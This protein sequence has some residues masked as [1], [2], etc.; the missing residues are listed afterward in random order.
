MPAPALTSPPTLA[1]DF[2]RLDPGRDERDR[3]AGDPDTSKGSDRKSSLPYEGLRVL[4]LGTFWAAPF[5]GAYLGSLG[6]EVIKIESVQRPDPFRYTGTFQQLGP[7]WQEHGGLFQGTNLNKRNITLDLN[8][9]QG[10]ALFERLVTN[11]DVVVENYSARVMDNF[12][13]GYERLKDLNPRVIMVRMPGFGLEG[14]WRD[15]VAWAMVIEQAAGMAWL[16]GDADGPPRNPGGFIDPVVG[17]HAVMAILAAL[18][19]RETTGEGQM[20][21]IAQ[22]ELAAVLSAE[23]VMAWTRDGDFTGRS[24]NRSDEIAPQGVYQCAGTTDWVA[25]SVRDDD[26]WNRLVDLLGRPAWAVDPALQTT[27]GRLMHHD[28]L[29]VGLAAWAGSRKALDMVGELVSQG[30]PATRL[31]RAAD[32]EDDPQL[33][34]RRFFQAIEH[35]ISGVRNFPGWPVQWSWRDLGTH[36]VSVTPTLGQHNEVVLGHDLGL[37]QSDLDGL[38]ADEIIG[39]QPLHR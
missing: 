19:H 26:E 8:R 33:A 20:I 24:G 35:P 37:S 6:A 10:R 27:G 14:P 5:T 7:D 1:D 13:L 12:G 31:M 15:Y 16:T 2:P 22:L 17:L 9:P 38:L 30:I 28:A 21:E 18:Q 25:L 23:Q 4:D 32:M 3:D 39:T 29:D 36:H 11:A 34:A